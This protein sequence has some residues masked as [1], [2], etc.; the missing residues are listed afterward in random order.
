MG[1]RRCLARTSLKIGLS[2][3][4]M[5]RYFPP[6]DCLI[7]IWEN[8]GPEGNFH[9]SYL[10]FILA[11]AGRKK[12]VLSGIARLM[13]CDGDSLSTISRLIYLFEWL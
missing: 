12:M 13:P 4:W 9:R 11:L 2:C 7:L 6:Y 10:E 5:S 3:S 1:H 8:L